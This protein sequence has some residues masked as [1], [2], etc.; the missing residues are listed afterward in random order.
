MQF[1]ELLTAGPG[2][3]AGPNAPYGDKPEWQL[4]E[5]NQKLPYA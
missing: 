2:G 5:I 1:Q 3:P 4:T